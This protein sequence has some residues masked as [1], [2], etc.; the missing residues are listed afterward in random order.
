MTLGSHAVRLSLRQKTR[1]SLY[2]HRNIKR[3]SGLVVLCQLVDL[4]RIHHTVTLQRGRFLDGHTSTTMG[5]GRQMGTIFHI[6]F[7]DTRRQENGLL[8]TCRKSRTANGFGLP[9]PA[10][11]SGATGPIEI[12]LSVSDFLMAP[13]W[14]RSMMYLLW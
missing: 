8:N 1:N 3:K 13:P 7:G 12:V 11:L 2:Y 4:S 14:L 5:D 10:P 9:V 6:V